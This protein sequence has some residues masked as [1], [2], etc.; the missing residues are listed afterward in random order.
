MNFEFITE[1]QRDTA[2]LSYTYT[3]QPLRLIKVREPS[4]SWV[5][6]NKT[7]IVN[8]IKGIKK[9]NVSQVKRAWHGR[10]GEG[11]WGEEGGWATRVVGGGSV[12][13]AANNLRVKGVE[14]AVFYANPGGIKERLI[15]KANQSTAPQ[16]VRYCPLYGLAKEARYCAADRFKKALPPLSVYLCPYDTSLY[17]TRFALRSMWHEPQPLLASRLL[18][19]VTPLI[20]TLQTND[21]L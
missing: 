10:C 5:C 11:V 18:F 9:W 16:L 14:G 4:R 17:Y 1:T 19:T 8:N 15:A 13:V 3:F 20:M 2:Q 21:S 7:I 6:K 12:F